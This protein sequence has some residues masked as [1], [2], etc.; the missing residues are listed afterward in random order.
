[1][2]WLTALIVEVGPWA[3]LAG[4]LLWWI[5]KQLAKQDTANERTIKRLQTTE[6]WIRE[7]LL[8]TTNKV[9]DALAANASAMRESVQAQ[10]DTQRV[11]REI[12][13][14]LR[15]RPCMHDADLPDAA[16]QPPTE[17]IVRRGRDHA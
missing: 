9:T 4:L 1:M 5:H 2:D 3:A 17:P 11:N 8:A 13:I 12:L 6:D 16:H 15:S 7:N 14:A 10:R